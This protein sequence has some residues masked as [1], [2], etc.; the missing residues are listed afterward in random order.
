MPTKHPLFVDL[1]KVKFSPP[2]LRDRVE[3]SKE[4]DPDLK[5]RIKK[6]NN[7]VKTRLNK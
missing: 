6:I 2:E 4:L 1:D 3:I 5:A 7:S